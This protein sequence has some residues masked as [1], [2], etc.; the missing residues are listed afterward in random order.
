MSSRFALALLL[1]SLGCRRTTPQA[2]ASADAAP[3]APTLVAPATDPTEDPTPPRELPPAEQQPESITIGTGTTIVPGAPAPAPS[4]DPFDNA[5][6]NVR[7]SALGCFSSMPPGEYTA[8]I[9]VNVTATG[10]ATRVEVLSGPA[11]AAVRKCL[12]SAATRGYPSSPNGR[13]L[14]I[15]VQVKV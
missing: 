6:A 11:D 14:T 12:E 3:P 9:A 10:T 7:A 2:S 5:I 4:V 15:D 8:S 1:V 13:K